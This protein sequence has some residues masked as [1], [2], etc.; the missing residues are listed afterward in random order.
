MDKEKQQLEYQVKRWK[1]KLRIA[2]TMLKKWEQKQKRFEKTLVIAARPTM[3][4]VVR[5][6]QLEG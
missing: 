6:I 1:R 3:G 5:R 4:N 2:N